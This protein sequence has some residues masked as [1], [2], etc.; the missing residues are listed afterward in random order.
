M[1]A[2]SVSDSRTMAGGCAWLS[3]VSGR[4]SLWMDVFRSIATRHGM[5]F[6]VQSAT[7]V[8]RLRIAKWSCRRV[9]IRIEQTKRTLTLLRN[10]WGRRYYRLRGLG[11]MLAPVACDA[12]QACPVA[13]S[14]TYQSKRAGSRHNGLLWDMRCSR[15]QEIL[16]HTLPRAARAGQENFQN[17]QPMR[18]RRAESPSTA[19]AGD[20]IPSK[21][22]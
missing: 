2:N 3:R 7:L 11:S 17:P 18:L 13:R 9:R 19:C 5:A 21:P 1:T 15:Y 12:F 16:R 6:F 20:P 8:S 22:T 4:T 10:D 14:H